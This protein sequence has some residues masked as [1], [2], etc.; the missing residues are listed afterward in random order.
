[1]LKLLVKQYC[2]WYS[3]CMFIWDMCSWEMNKWSSPIAT[4]HHFLFVLPYSL[5][6][7]QSW[8]PINRILVYLIMPISTCTHTHVPTYK[9]VHTLSYTHAHMCTHK[10]THTHNPHSIHMHMNMHM[11]TQRNKYTNED[12]PLHQ[13]FQFP[14]KF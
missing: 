11:Y 2:Y 6:A 1:M 4:T 14:Q 7:L 13:F 8:K 3:F 5:W 12:L 9:Y 10:Y